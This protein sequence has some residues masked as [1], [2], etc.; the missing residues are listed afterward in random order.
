MAIDATTGGVAANS[1]MADAAFVA[2]GTGSLASSRLAAATPDTRERALRTAARMI[3]RMGFAGEATAYAQAL[4]WPRRAVRDPDR[5]GYMIPE[6]IVPRR[7]TE[8]SAELALALLGE[9]EVSPDG[10][11]S[12]S[13]LYSRAKVDVIEVEYRDGAAASTDARGVLKRYPAAYA[14]LAPL[15]ASGG[16]LTTVRA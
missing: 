14:L 8:A 12:K 9:G 4:Q 5:I 3:D 13:A 16:M 1:Y 6:T 2:Y 7:I 11:M 10:A 15:L